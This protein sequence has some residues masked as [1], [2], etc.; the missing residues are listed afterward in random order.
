MSISESVET[1]LLFDQELKQ[2]KKSQPL[3]LVGK[4]A[5]ISAIALAAIASVGFCWAGAA[6]IVAIS[7]P[8]IAWISIGSSSFSFLVGIDVIAGFLLFGKK[9][10]SVVISK[11]ISKEIDEHEDQAAGLRETLERLE[12]NEILL[13]ERDARIASLQATVA[14]GHEREQRLRREI[15]QR[16]KETA[17]ESDQRIR[18]L[19]DELAT[20]VSLAESLQTALR[21]SE[22]DLAKQERGAASANG[23][24]LRALEQ[25]VSRLERELQTE[26]SKPKT[27]QKDGR[28]A[29]LEDSLEALRAEK[30]SFD[31]RLQASAAELASQV[32][33]IEELREEIRRLRTEQESKRSEALMQAQRR[34]A[35]AEEEN[36]QLKADIAKQKAALE[37]EL[38]HVQT[39]LIA[40][41]ARA[42]AEADE[43][44]VDEQILEFTKHYEGRFQALLK[45]TC[46]LQTENGTF[47]LHHLERNAE[48]I[49]IAVEKIAMVKWAEILRRLS[50]LDT[51]AETFK[52]DLDALKVDTEKALGRL[53]QQVIWTVLQEELR[54]AFL[55]IDK[56]DDGQ[57]IGSLFDPYFAKIL[58]HINGDSSSIHPDFRQACDC[59]IK[60]K[61]KVENLMSLIAHLSQYEKAV[62]SFVKREFQI[63]LPKHY[64][65]DM[66]QTR[67]LRI[68]QAHAGEGKSPTQLVDF[69]ALTEGDFA[70]FRDQWPGL[71]DIDP[72]AVDL[73]KL[74]KHWSTQEK[75]DIKT[76]E[77]HQLT[78]LL[79]NVFKDRLLASQVKWFCEDDPG[80]FSQALKKATTLNELKMVFAERVYRAQIAEL[81]DWAKEKHNWSKAQVQELIEDSSFLSSAH[82]RYLEVVTDNV[83]ENLKTKI[84][85]IEKA[86]KL[87][88][89]LCYSNPQSSLQEQ[90]DA[91]KSQLPNTIQV[92][93]AH[94]IQAAQNELILSKIEF[95]LR[96]AGNG[97]TGQL[98]QR[99]PLWGNLSKN[100][101]IPGSVELKRDDILGTLQRWGDTRWI[102]RLTDRQMQEQVNDTIDTHLLVNTDLYQTLRGLRDNRAKID[103]LYRSLPP[104]QFGQIAA[105]ML[106]EVGEGTKHTTAARVELHRILSN[107]LKRNKD[108]ARNLLLGKHYAWVIP[109][110][111]YLTDLPAF[112]NLR[113]KKTSDEK[114]AREW[115]FV[116][117]VSSDP[118][119]AMGE[120]SLLG[121]SATTAG[122]KW[123]Y[124]PGYSTPVHELMHHVYKYG[125]ASGLSIS[126]KSLAELQVQVKDLYAAKKAKITASEGN[127]VVYTG[128]RYSTGETKSC[129]YAATDEHEWS[130]EF[131]TAFFE[132]NGVI[133]IGRNGKPVRQTTRGQILTRQELQKLGEEEKAMCAIYE[134]I[135]GRDTYI[136]YCNPRYDR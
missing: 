74:V 8:V 63:E 59:V 91:L 112:A 34:Q 132:A 77:D 65:K 11:E 28:V 86:E 114:G 4:I 31:S 104:K 117:G 119:V 133:A 24:D 52:S 122:A 37:S 15:A 92:D 43:A 69:L 23:D 13:A 75:A 126:G 103:E 94:R 99:N 66:D 76:M 123:K 89:Q 40:L 125:M 14:T 90:Y 116:R 85:R 121:I 124:D 72:E 98:T 136:P 45:E 5:V 96:R 36:V 105:A 29:E 93:H 58:S 67:L 95:Q 127:H 100:L 18:E 30:R 3:E 101:D 1:P 134:D 17:G 26:R 32:T 47:D 55:V 57:A 44:P 102:Y 60:T 25:K 110:G 35:A 97:L 83:F 79:Q 41:R 109:E 68:L 12:A 39:E 64:L 135:F 120:E 33:T 54:T 115:K 82:K 19:E 78:S 106:I 62:T 84:D 73:M 56:I 7:L 131:A 27:V 10:P 46:R 20:Q 128:W 87:V 6:G 22:R 108:V 61:Q 107:M 42:I 129:S 130:A 51:D 80:R 49:P 9:A 38:K 70:Q 50:A 111:K 21:R 71:D 113:G 2:V 118:A 16:G 81:E 88:Q 53:P 48:G